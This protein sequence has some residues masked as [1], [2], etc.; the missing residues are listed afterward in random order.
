M[1]SYTLKKRNLLIDEILGL[2]GLSK[3]LKFSFID[4]C[5][6]LRF[7][8]DGVTG[9]RQRSLY[10]IIVVPRNS[11]FGHNEPVTLMPCRPVY[12]ALVNR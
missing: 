12:V 10:W 11:R 7:G 9:D 3:G 5:V 6:I 1:G 4:P 2:K 8:T